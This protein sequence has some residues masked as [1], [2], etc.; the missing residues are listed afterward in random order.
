MPIQAPIIDA[1]RATASSTG[2]RARI[3]LSALRHN[4]ARVHDFCP[5]AKVMAVIKA[6]AYGHGLCEVATALSAADAFAVAR[7]EEASAL[8][9]AGC[10]KPLLLLEGVH[11]DLALAQARDLDLACVVHA[12]HQLVLFEQANQAMPLWLKVDTGMHRLGFAPRDVKDALSRL[13]AIT[14]DIVLMSHFACAD[15]SG[16]EATRHQLQQFDSVTDTLTYPTSL[17]NSA[18]I[19]AWP[20]AHRDWVRPGIMLYGASPLLDI[21]ADMLDLQPVMELHSELIAIHDLQAGDT[22]GYGA[23]YVCDRVQ[24]IGVVAAGYADGYPRHAPSGTPVWVAGQRAPLVG[25]VSMDMITVDLSDISDADIGSSAVL[26][27]RDLPV[28]EIAQCAGTI[29]YDLLCGVTARVQYE[30]VD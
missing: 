19:V 23:A 5:D 16:S 9:D 22:V 26:W 24:R 2:V 17:A 13:R 14:D 28:D 18:G 25:R 20:D 12:P 21:S 6:N 27:G 11:D 15:E 4:L 8:R 3:D 29:A 30:F 1:V 7:I 10:D